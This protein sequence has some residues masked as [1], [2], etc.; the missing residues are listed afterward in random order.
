[1]T[2]TSLPPFP[3]HT[4]ASAPE[5][6]RPA[7]ERLEASVGSIPSLAGAM[8]HVPALIE[9]FVALREAFGKT[10]FTPLEREVLALTNASENGCRY[11]MAIHATFAGKAGLP[12]GDIERLRTREVP[13]DAR[14]A[15]LSGLSRELIRGRGSVPAEAL[16]AFLDADFRP[17]QVLEVIVGIATSVL[18]NYSGHV[19]AT[20]PDAAIRPQYR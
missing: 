12:A 11:C 7:L 8:A 16:R 15:A 14:L 6:S 2:K 19:T 5:A 9:G 3:P 4:L 1:M 17:A 20:E 13:S 10:S 18:A